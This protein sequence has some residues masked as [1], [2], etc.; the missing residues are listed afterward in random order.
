MSD[1]YY[2]EGGKVIGVGHSICDNCYCIR[3]LI[4]CEPISCAPPLLGCSPVVREGECCASSYNCSKKSPNFVI[5]FCIFCSLPL[6]GGAIET[7]PEPNY[8]N[9]TILSKDYAKLRRHQQQE[10]Q[11]LKPYQ[12]QDQEKSKKGTNVPYYVLAESF[13]QTNMKNSRGPGTFGTTRQFTGTTLDPNAK[14]TYRNDIS[15]LNSIK[16]GGYEEKKAKPSVVGDNELLLHATTNYKYF[17]SLN[18][19]L[20]HS[21]TGKYDSSF[22]R[23][24]DR[25]QKHE[26]SVGNDE[27]L[28]AGV[29]DE[30]NNRRIDNENKTK[31]HQELNDGSNNGSSS[32][33]S[34]LVNGTVHGDT[35]GGE[36]G[37]GYTSVDLTGIDHSDTSGVSAA[38]NQSGSAIKNTTLITNVQNKSPDA[39]RNQTGNTI[40]EE[41]S[42]EEHNEEASTMTTG[43][44]TTKEYPTTTFG[45]LNV[46]EFTIS[47]LGD[48]ASTILSTFEDVFINVLNSTN[49]TDDDDAENATT[50]STL[51]IGDD[52]SKNVT[53]QIMESHSNATNSS[54]GN[55]GTLIE[56]FPTISSNNNNIVNITKRI[57]LNNELSERNATINNGK[58]Q[59]TDEGVKNETSTMNNVDRLDAELMR[60]DNTSLAMRE[61]ATFYGNVH[62]EGNATLPGNGSLQRNVSLER[63]GDLEINGALETN[64]ASEKNV[65]LAEENDEWQ[66][67]TTR[68]HQDSDHSSSSN[69]SITTNNE[70]DITI[71]D[72]E[73]KVK[74][75]T[76]A[77]PPEIEAILNRTKNKNDDYDDYDYNE[78]SLPPSLPNLK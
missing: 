12:P 76:A 15:K 42:T 5:R 20:V 53:K 34:E 19:K 47:T 48:T 63:N 41:S 35:T 32:S 13:Q 69:T 1:R 21:T 64:K 49:C 60:K 30:R 52:F 31:T 26:V 58:L 4:R 11:H 7:E 72:L 51:N 65:T 23:I 61:N 57:D 54:T 33:Q 73:S 39:T 46:D 14:N 3:G 77:I 40:H 22:N 71:V 62:L 36:S 6:T 17:N 43:V 16:R 55:N 9:Y 56:T 66:K 10:E 2:R 38:N 59:R 50:S 8:G 74:V 70:E 37:V 24:Q 75:A 18:H 45:D 29:L 28:V 25:Y 27:D 44:D 68:P 67:N 78:P